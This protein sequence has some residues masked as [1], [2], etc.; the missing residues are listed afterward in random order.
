[1]TTPPSIAQHVTFV[2]VA[3][4][5]RSASFYAGA[6]GLKLTL[7]QGPCRIYRVTRD[8]FIG[9]CTRADAPRPDGVI[10]TLVVP[11]REDVDAWAE[12]LTRL[13]VALEKPPTYHE[14]YDIYHVFIRDPDGYLVEVQVFEDP[15]WPA[16]S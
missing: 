2:Y 14:T 10:M 8:A 5:E 13:G 1:L 7:D 12:H 6:L 11:T 15:T 4:L 9:T 3:D 16:A